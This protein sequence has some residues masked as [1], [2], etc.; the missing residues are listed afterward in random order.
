MFNSSHLWLLRKELRTFRYA[1]PFRPFAH[2]SPSSIS[3]RC[4][5]WWKGRQQAKGG[6]RKRRRGSRKW[7][8]GS[9]GVDSQNSRTL[10][11]PTPADR[12]SWPSRGSSRKWKTRKWRKATAR[13]KRKGYSRTFLLETEPGGSTESIQKKSKLV[14]NIFEDGFTG[15]SSK[16]YTGKPI[17]QN[18]R[19]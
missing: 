4:S 7:P 16:S 9:R 19:Q 15:G 13:P 14:N 5:T 6:G 8:W 2:P 10:T 11:F 3:R 12:P 17:S 18:L 1:S